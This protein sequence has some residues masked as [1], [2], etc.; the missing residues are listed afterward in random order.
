LEVVI[1]I[2]GEL[3]IQV[4]FEVLA[5]FGLHSVKETSRKRPNPTL[6][7]FGYVLLGAAAGG[8]SLL[9]APTSLVPEE[10]RVANLVLV[11]LIAG[12]AMVGLG[13]WRAKRGQSLVRLDRFVY[14][15]LFALALAAV[16]FQFAG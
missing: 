5:E 15:Y 4:V 9:L 16:R 8:V 14:G 3:L 2:V 7:V 12:A 10:W 13:A 6:A 11:P 1:E